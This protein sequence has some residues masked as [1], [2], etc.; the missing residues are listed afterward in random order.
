[1]WHRIP[2]ESDEVEATI[3]CFGRDKYLEYKKDMGGVGSFNFDNRTLY[4]GRV[5]VSDDM[6]DIVRRHF[7]EWGP[8]ESGK[9]PCSG[10][11][12]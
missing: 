2:T 4:V 3:D 5:T 10:R 1:M 8:I 7:S 11:H 12:W 9:E 6:E